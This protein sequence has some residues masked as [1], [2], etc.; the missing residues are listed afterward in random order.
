MRLINEPLEAAVMNGADLETGAACGLEHVKNPILLAKA[1]MEKSPYVYM[2][3]KGA[4]ALANKCQLEM[5]DQSYYDDEIRHALV[6]EH[7]DWNAANDMA[8]QLTADTARQ[9]AILEK[10]LEE[11]QAAVAALRRGSAE[12]RNALDWTGG[13]GVR[14]SGSP[15]ADQL[16][17]GRVA[18]SQGDYLATQA[19]SMKAA[20]TAANA[21]ISATNLVARRR[22][23]AQRRAAEERRRR[24]AS[25]RRSSFSTSSLSS[26]RG[27]SMFGGGGIG[28]GSRGSFSSS[29]G[30]SRSS[31]STGSGFSRSGW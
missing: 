10:E 15:G 26:S 4:E 25:R 21:V 20:R 14:I 30:G 8:D 24:E 29:S 18:L 1:V 27:G 7:G 31:F 9:I 5:V 19:L 12:V 16:E 2:Y 13:Y 28:G 3:G 6:R 17:H 22:R 11:A 23:E